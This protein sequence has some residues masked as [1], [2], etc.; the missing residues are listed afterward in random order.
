MEDRLPCNTGDTDHRGKPTVDVSGHSNL[1][2]LQSQTLQVCS[3][4][5]MKAEFDDECGPSKGARSKGVGSGGR[6][7]WGPF[8]IVA[9]VIP[10]Q[11][12][13]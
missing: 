11:D 8:G 3:E 10:L 6:G 12:V 2:R 7:H 4:I 1:G 5:R 13:P 9:D